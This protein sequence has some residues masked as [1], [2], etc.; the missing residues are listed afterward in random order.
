M[1]GKHGTPLERFERH[2]T[3]EPNSGCWLWIGSIHARTGYGYINMPGNTPL[4]AH[5]LAYT[6]FKGLIPKGLDVRHTCDTRCCVNP[7]HLLVGT[8]KQNMEDAE[9]RG[10]IAR[11]FRLPH[12][13]LSNAQIALIVADSRLHREIAE[14]YKVHKAYISTL[15]CANGAGRYKCGS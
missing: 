1:V 5:R 10:K 9:R 6:L 15:K 3:P 7:D 14:D 11:G 4:R 8:R 13:R 12:T 2:Y